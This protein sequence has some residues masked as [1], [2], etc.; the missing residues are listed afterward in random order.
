VR[1][2]GEISGQSPEAVVARA[3]VRLQAGD[4]AGA[5]AEMTTLEGQLPENDAWLAR[6]R[7]RLAAERALDALNAGLVAIG[8]AG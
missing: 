2:T 3:E 4:L 8:G 6:A 1:R 7:L 5:V